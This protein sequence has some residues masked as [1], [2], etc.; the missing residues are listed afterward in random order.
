MATDSL[1]TE[2]EEAKQV[3][4][5]QFA[6]RVKAHTILIELEQE[7]STLRKELGEIQTMA[8]DQVQT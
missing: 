2:L 1:R 4:R 3:I 6:N 7:N 8:K 5:D